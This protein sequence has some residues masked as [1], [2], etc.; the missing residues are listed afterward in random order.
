VSSS[1]DRRVHPAGLEPRAPRRTAE[2]TG[3][4]PGAGRLTLRRVRLRSVARVGCSLGWLI[5]LLPALLTSALAAW[6]LHNI[7]LTLNGWTPWRPWEPGQRMAGIPLPTPPEFRPREAL[8]VEGAYQFLEPVGQ[9]PF[10]ATLLGALALTLLGG[11]LLALIF[12]LAGAGYNT[13]ARLTG[14]IEFDVAPTGGRPERP[15]PGDPRHRR[16][17]D[18]ERDWDETELQW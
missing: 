10:V 15:A 6:V 4:V 3:S 12:L 1:R 14:G 5:S 11:A 16:P 7:W 17:A 8:R 13:F 2:T 9:H 18:A